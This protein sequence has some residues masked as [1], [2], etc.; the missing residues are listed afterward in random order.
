MRTML[1]TLL[2]TCVLLLLPG[3]AGAAPAAEIPPFQIAAVETAVKAIHYKD[4]KGSI[5]ID[6]AGTELLPQA[7][8][9]ARIASSAG[10]IEIDARFKNLTSV[11]QFGRE[12][13]T[14]VFWAISPDG[15][16]ENL[17]ELI[18]KNGKSR[19]EADTTLQAVSLFVTAEPYFAVS[20]PSDIV[21]LENAIQPDNREGIELVDAT[22]M[23]LPRAPYTKDTSATAPLPRAMDSQTPLKVYQARNAVRI[24]KAAGAATYA[25]DRFQE[26]ERLLAL[27][28]TK[29][30]SEKS[31]D[32]SARQAIQSAEASRVLAVEL[33]AA[34]L[35]AKKQ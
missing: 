27:S 4:M 24:A 6:F 13:L 16:A 11:T 29:G 22:V 30:D 35:L 18:L 1:T 33:Q 32:M 17:G 31:R 2:S 8:G 14:Y 25:K 15:S 28:E 19:I 10:K 26:A 5:E 12:Y 7:N 3:T 23:L 34:E 9:S 20:Q 21:V